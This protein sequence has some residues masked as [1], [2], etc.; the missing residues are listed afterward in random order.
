M[1]FLVGLVSVGAALT[2]VA[3]S[4]LMNWV[5]MSSLG[6][7]EFEQQ[8]LGAVSVAVSAFLALLSDR[9]LAG[10]DRCRYPQELLY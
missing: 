2:L 9:V 8:I 6:R 5:F 7:S 4:G 10:Q 1:R 3:A